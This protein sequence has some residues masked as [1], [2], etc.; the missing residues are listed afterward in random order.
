MTN[1]NIRKLR[2]TDVVILY[3]LDSVSVA[4]RA[5]NRDDLKVLLS[6]YPLS[7]YLHYSIQQVCVVL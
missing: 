6:Q 4:V 1:F 3:V 7:K 2:F 5:Q